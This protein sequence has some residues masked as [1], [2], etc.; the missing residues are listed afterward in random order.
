MQ[1]LLAEGL[2]TAFLLIA[3]VGSGIMGAAL[4]DGNVAVALLANAIATGCMLYAIITT[5]GPISGAHF[6]PAVTLAFWLRGE[7][8]SLLALKYVA[9]QIF[10]GILGVWAAHLMFDLNILQLSTTGRSGVSQWFSEGLATFGLL[11]VIFGGLRSRP[12]AVPALVALYITGAYWFTSSTSFANP[13][14][15]IARGFS[16][17]FAGIMPSHVPMFIVMQI[18]GVGVAALVL[19]RLFAKG[20]T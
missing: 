20:P 7:I 5:L 15:T 8:D 14:V 18:V 17:T 3:V 12:E 2:G 16:D 11:F 1:K 9:V 6:N 4:S 19:P 13:A 10:G